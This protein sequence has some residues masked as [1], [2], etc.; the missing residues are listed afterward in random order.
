MNYSTRL[1]GGNTD[2]IYGLAKSLRVMPGDVI[3]S[4]SLRKFGPDTN[5]WT[6]ALNN[7]IT[8]IVNGTARPEH[9]WMAGLQEA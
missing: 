8:S 7:F 3:M 6:T 5:E 1:V 4:K 9:L 2:E